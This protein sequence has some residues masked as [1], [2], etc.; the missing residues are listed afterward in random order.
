MGTKEYRGRVR[1]V[2]GYVTPTTYFHSVKKTSKRKEE[3]ILESKELRRHVSELEARIHSN[4]STP[5]SRHESCSKSN[6]LEESESMKLIKGKNK[7][8]NKIK[9]KKVEEIYVNDDKVELDIFKVYDP[10][11]NSDV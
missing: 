7:L 5:L 9:E 3:I 10:L 2:G 8:M 4:L 1:G 11:I 6:I